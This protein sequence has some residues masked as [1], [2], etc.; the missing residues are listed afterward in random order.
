MNLL[1]LYNFSRPYFSLAFSWRFLA[2][3]LLLLVAVGWYSVTQHSWLNLN[4]ASLPLS[5]YALWSLAIIL[6]TLF[7]WGCSPVERKLAKAISL[8]NQDLRR[9]DA[10]QG[11]QQANSALFLLP[12]AKIKLG[13]L[14]AA[15]YRSQGEWVKAYNTLQE[16]QALPL[17]PKERTAIELDFMWLLYESGNFKATQHA[18]TRL[19]KGRLTQAQ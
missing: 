14:Q 18:L 17:L 4:L 6:S 13:S 7:A 1:S 11:L 19:Q 15:F 9:S 10:E 12:S 3:T 8:A 16:L 5:V 2:V